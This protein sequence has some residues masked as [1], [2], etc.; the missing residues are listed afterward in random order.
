MTMS[1][2]CK[3]PIKLQRPLAFNGIE[4]EMLPNHTFSLSREVIDLLD[5]CPAIFF[6]FQIATSIF[7]SPEPKAHR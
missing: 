4:T 2:Y 5:C 1:A 7:S 6:L 3:V